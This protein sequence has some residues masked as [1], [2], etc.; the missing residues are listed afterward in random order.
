MTT[1]AASPAATIA[2]VRSSDSGPTT[3]RRVATAMTHARE[4][5]MSTFQPKAMNWS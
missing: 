2:G 5:G 3:T 1:N 4:T